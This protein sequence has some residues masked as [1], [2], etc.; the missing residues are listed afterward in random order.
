MI[1]A[2]S[3]SPDKK[4]PSSRGPWHQSPT[5]PM[6]DLRIPQVTLEQRPNGSCIKP[7]V[8]R[9]ERRTKAEVK[10]LGQR[11]RQQRRHVVAWHVQVQ[12]RPIRC[13]VQH[14]ALST[15]FV[16]F[17]RDPRQCSMVVDKRAGEIKA[18]SHLQRQQ[19]RPT[20]PPLDHSQMLHQR[21]RN[22]RQLRGL[23]RRHRKHDR[24][25]TARRRRALGFVEQ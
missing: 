14:P 18:A 21:R 8:R 22:T 19:R 13:R 7:A 11:L 2:P 10:P 1:A 15:R 17:S 4:A 25:E 24:V 3:A 20:R 16:I 12:N 5:A 6:R 23:R 9:D